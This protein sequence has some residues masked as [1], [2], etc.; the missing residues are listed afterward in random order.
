[1]ETFNQPLEST[2]KNTPQ[3]LWLQEVQPV[4]SSNLESQLFNATPPHTSDVLPGLQI[5]DSRA[6][7]SED[8]SSMVANVARNIANDTT[9]GAPNTKAGDV[10]RSAGLID[11]ITFP[12]NH[13]M[14]QYNYSDRSTGRISDLSMGGRQVSFLYDGD[15]LSTIIFSG[16]RQRAAIT[17]DSDGVTRSDGK[18]ISTDRNQLGYDIYNH[19]RG[20]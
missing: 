6:P 15:A 14:L 7:H 13:Q 3:Q 16:G 17:I 1:M 11:Q 12:N 20:K 2:Q 4:S 9:F 10:S 18:Q 5:G 8:V 19:L